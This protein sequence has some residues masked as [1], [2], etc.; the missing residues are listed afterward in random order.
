MD[1]WNTGSLLGWP[2]FR[3]ELLVSGRVDDAKSLPNIPEKPQHAEFGSFLP[4]NTAKS[5]SINQRFF[6]APGRKNNMIRYAYTP[7]N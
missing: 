7:E 1:G 6:F 3:G 4:A 5:I 2:I